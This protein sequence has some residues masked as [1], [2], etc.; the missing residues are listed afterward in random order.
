MADITRTVAFRQNILFYATRTFAGHP[1]NPILTVSN[2]T[3]R[4]EHLPGSEARPN[5]RYYR[6]I[7]RNARERERNTPELCSISAHNAPI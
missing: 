4:P 2:L 1:Q 5:P 3:N 7:P 6:E